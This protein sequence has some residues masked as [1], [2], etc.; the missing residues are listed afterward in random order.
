MNA[1]QYLLL[2]GSYFFSRIR[3][4]GSSW[5]VDT[6]ILVLLAKTLSRWIPAFRPDHLA[7][8]LRLDETPTS[9]CLARGMSLCVLVHPFLLYVAFDA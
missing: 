4:V 5:T 3:E 7:G 1:S 6:W 8:F 2:L 9:M